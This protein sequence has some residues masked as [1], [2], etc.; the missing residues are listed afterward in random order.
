M[1]KIIIFHVKFN[2]DT[3]RITFMVY[4]VNLRF[5]LRILTGTFPPATQ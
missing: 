4:V 2:M 5:C 1:T 3:L